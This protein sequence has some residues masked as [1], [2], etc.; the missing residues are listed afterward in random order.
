[1]A[2]V[3]AASGDSVLANFCKLALETDLS[4]AQLRKVAIAVIP[5]K[6]TEGMVKTLIGTLHSM[7]A[8]EYATLVKRCACGNA[9]ST[10]DNAKVWRTV[11]RYDSADQKIAEI[12]ANT[13]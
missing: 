4:D 12:N 2:R 13:R 3:S 5:G 10:A 11:E 6:H 1:M 8:V 9:I 7:S